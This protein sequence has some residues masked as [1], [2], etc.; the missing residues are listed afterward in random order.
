M[1]IVEPSYEI[2]DPSP[3]NE[4]VASA[5]LR[6]IERAGR[7]CYK[8]ESRITE[9]SA[10]KFVR[11]LCRRGHE[12]V[13]EHESI[14]VLFVVDRGVS[15]ELVRHR[16]CSFSQE[17]TRY[18]N[19]GKAG[20]VTFV[21]PCF[22]LDDIGPGATDRRMKRWERAMRDS[23]AA[24]LEELEIGA[25]PEEARSVLP[26]SLKTEIAMTSNMR[27]WRHILNLRTSN[28]AHPQ[29]RQVMVP[30]LAE[31]RSVLGPVFDE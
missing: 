17:S 30:L 7:V 24:Y 31:L 4:E 27:Q 28:K 6:R 5:M 12:S 18:C 13:L 16:V 22:W 14:S 15:H 3:L 2:I 29:M 21:R 20:E 9:D 26:N 19:Y 1:Q 11:M 8:S 23:E 25:T 10:G